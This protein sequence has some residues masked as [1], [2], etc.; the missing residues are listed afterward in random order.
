MADVRKVIQI[1]DPQ[2]ANG[3]HQLG[4]IP[5]SGSELLATLSGS[6]N[7]I[8]TIAAGIAYVN[9]R[10]IR[11]GEVTAAT[12]TPAAD[13]GNFRYDLLSVHPDGTFV[14]SEGTLGGS[15]P[16][17]PAGYAPIS[18]WAML[19]GAAFATSV[20]D[21]RVRYPLDGTFMVDDTIATRHIEAGAVDTAELA[22]DAVTEQKIGFD[23]LSPSIAFGTEDVNHDIEV[24]IQ[25]RQLDLSTDSG[26]VRRFRVWAT[27]DSGTPEGTDAPTFTTPTTFGTRIT[28]LGDNSAIYETD[29]TGKLVFLWSGAVGTTGKYHLYVQAV[30]V[31]GVAVQAVSP[32]WA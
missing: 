9:G 6:T 8:D 19:A 18:S 5:G 21:E 14:I 10:K 31:A 22:N 11:F 23:F 25:S 12:A 15:R 28:T 26:T 3:D 13:G 16:S 17:P 24:T 29:A 2:G 1:G 7:E 30:N 27:D 20:V 4:W 32:T